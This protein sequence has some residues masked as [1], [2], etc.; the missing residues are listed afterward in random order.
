MKPICVPT[1]APEPDFGL[2]GLTSSV[3][4]SSSSLHVCFRVCVRL[5]P[6]L[7]LCT[8]QHLLIDNG[9]TD[10]THTHTP[11]VAGRRKWRRK[12]EE[13]EINKV[14]WGLYEKKGPPRGQ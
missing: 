8:Q 5:N 6:Y 1:S 2:F 12:E 10:H 11:A 9:E 13:R 14:E 3:L 7:A 4:P